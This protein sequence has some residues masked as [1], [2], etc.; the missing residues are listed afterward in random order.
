MA[1]GFTARLHDF[2][3]VSVCHMRRHRIDRIGEHRVKC[4]VIRAISKSSCVRQGHEEMPAGKYSLAEP[5]QNL[6]NAAQL[7]QLT[8]TS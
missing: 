7:A 6:A 1:R 5:E 2:G 3:R 8:K 4:C